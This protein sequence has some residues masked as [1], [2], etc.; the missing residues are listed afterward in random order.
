MNNRVLIVDDS[1]TVRMN[2]ADAFGLAGF[3]PLPCASLG[4]ARRLM[5]TD[6]VDAVILDVVLPDGDGVALLRELR[7]GP[8]DAIPVLMLS[9]EAEIQD[10]IRGLKT[11]ANEY[12]GKPYDAGY[13]IARTRQLLAH[14]VESGDSKLVLLIDDS[15]TVR[16]ELGAALVAGGYRVTLASSGEEGLRLAAQERP[17]GIVVDGVLPGIDGATVIRRVRLDA[18]LRGVPCILL[19][20]GSALT[21]LHALDSGADAFLKKTDDVAVVLAKIHAVLRTASEVQQS[22]RDG[23]AP[24]SQENFGCGR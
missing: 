6:R 8:N 22:R 5:A 15:L 3:H 1:L 4:E 12:V 21:E 13:V 17:A 16:T 24:R 11:G 20:A 19:T 9:T 18:A 7:E 2:L 14:S 10:R 23:G